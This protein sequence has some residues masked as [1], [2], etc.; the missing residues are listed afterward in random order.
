ML[1]EFEEWAGKNDHRYASTLDDRSFWAFNRAMIADGL[2]EK[3][4][5]DR[6]IIVK[7]LFKWAHRARRIGVNPFEGI[8]LRKPEAK[9]QPCFTPQQVATLLDRPDPRERV[10]FATMAYAGLLGL[11]CRRG[12]LNDAVLGPTDRA[13][14][15]HLD[16][17]GGL[18][19]AKAESD[20]PD[21]VFLIMHPAVR[22][23]A[24]LRLS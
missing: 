5:Y 8:S 3:T 19:Q 13:G 11:E 4:R 23:R 24:V 20:S 9:E 1:G 6:L 10:I 21:R 14:R 2:S 22:F 15:I 7:Q 17:V 12:P 18:I 16:G